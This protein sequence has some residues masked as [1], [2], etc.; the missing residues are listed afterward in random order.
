MLKKIEDKRR[1]QRRRT[2]LDGIID[3]NGHEFEQTPGDG[4]GQRSLVCCSHGVA[5][6]QT[7]LRDGTAKAPYYVGYRSSPWNV[8][9]ECRNLSLMVFQLSLMFLVP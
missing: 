4:E 3:S 2:W 5:K 6:S 9:A 8:H 1:E 7:R